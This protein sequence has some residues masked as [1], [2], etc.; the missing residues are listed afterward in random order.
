MGF[1]C[2]CWGIMALMSNGG[3]MLALLALFYADELY[4]ISLPAAGFYAW[5]FVCKGA[6]NEL[7]SWSLLISKLE[8]AFF[9]SE[10]T[11]G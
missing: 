3:I 5:L 1:N 9:Y 7:K 8:V 6:K 4:I 11:F 2:C 10:E